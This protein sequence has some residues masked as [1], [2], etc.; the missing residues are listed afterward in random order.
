MVVSVLCLTVLPFHEEKFLK[1]KLVLYL[2]NNRL[3]K[4][5][6][7]KKAFHL[8]LRKLMK[9]V[10]STNEKKRREQPVLKV[11]IKKTIKRILLNEIFR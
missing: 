11:K 6:N 5:M 10:V 7:R 9:F 8:P 3:M 2:C 4:T 1:L